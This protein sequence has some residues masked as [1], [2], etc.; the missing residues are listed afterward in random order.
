MDGDHRSKGGHISS[1]HR[2]TWSDSLRTTEVAG[3]VR[4]FPTMLEMCLGVGLG[5]W[6]PLNGTLSKSENNWWRGRAS[7]AR[8]I[9][10]I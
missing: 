10:G 8:V 4:K 1:E 3:L 2:L 6:E 5:V 9:A 7:Q